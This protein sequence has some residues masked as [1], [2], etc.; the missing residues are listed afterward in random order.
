MLYDLLFSTMGLSLLPLFTLLSFAFIFVC[1]LCIAKKP[2]VSF[3]PL[4][5]NF[6]LDS[7]SFSEVLG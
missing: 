2:F 5:N 6:F 7:V 1:F 3:D 4:L